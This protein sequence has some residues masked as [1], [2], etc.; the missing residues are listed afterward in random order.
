[1]LFFLH[2]IPETDSTNVL[3]RRYVAVQGWRTP[4]AVTADR[5]TGGRGRHGRVWCSPAGNVYL[6]ACFFPPVTM[7]HLPLSAYAAGIA[8]Y[9]T[10]K[11]FVPDAA[12]VLKWPNDV[13]V[14]GRKIA[15]I[16]IETVP[17]SDATA[18]IIGIGLNVAAVD[19]AVRE[20]ATC[21]ADHMAPPPALPTVRT[22]LLHRLTHWMTVWQTQPFSALK[23]C[24]ER[25]ATPLNTPVTVKQGETVHTGLY[26]GLAHDGALLLQRP[27]KSLMTLRQAD[28][29]EVQQSCSSP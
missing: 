22:T 10:V 15:G 20:R 13:L 19:E 14:E 23:P 1:M 27:D 7:D 28:V 21:L 4:F 25:R 8:V 3:A 26:R 29:F 12:V 9:E 6:S 11:Q 5:Q 18:L 24:W 16:L 17:L 2:H